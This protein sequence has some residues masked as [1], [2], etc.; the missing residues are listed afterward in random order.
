MQLFYNAFTMISNEQRNRVD[1]GRA[2][3]RAVLAQIVLRGPRS[4]TEIAAATDLTTASVSRITRELIES[5]LVVELPDAEEDNTPRSPGRRFIRLD[6]NS[7][8][9]YVLGIGVN[10]F[11]QSVTLADL[12]NRRIARQ[13]LN[14]SDLS[15]PDVVIRELADAAKRMIDTYVDDRRRLLGASF[16]ITGAV[17]PKERIVKSSPYLGWG[18]VALGQ[19][20]TSELGIP[21][22]IENHPNSLALAESWFGVAKGQK[23]L[24]TLNCSLGIGASLLL[25]GQLI[26]G[27]NFS[28]GLIGGNTPPEKGALSLDMCAGGQGIL[29]RVNGDWREVR[30]IPAD[31]AARQLLDTIERSR[32]GDATAHQILTETGY[33]LGRTIS[34]FIGLI[35][36]DAVM[37][38]GPLA[39][40]PAYVAAC[41]AGLNDYVADMEV[42]FLVSEMSVQSAARWLAIGEHLFEQDINLKNLKLANAA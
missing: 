6:I 23:H 42:E 11:H 25:D 33:S 28:A 8:G 26:R 15:D 13:D 3:R 20:L 5:G 32:G 1:L 38:A 18:E 12:K 27:K 31:N 39:R 17:D 2:N 16:A 35:R 29:S 36:P 9:G 7:R 19:R 30:K 34:Q 10:V 14:L 40:A 4:R 22:H 37:I 21:V 24:L 41:R